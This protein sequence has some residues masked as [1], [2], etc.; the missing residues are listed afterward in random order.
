MGPQILAHHLLLL[1]TAD[2]YDDDYEG[3]NKH[4]SRNCPAK[5]SLLHDKFFIGESEFKKT[6]LGSFSGKHMFHKID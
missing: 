5:T 2:L 6:Y 1:A 3:K 4:K